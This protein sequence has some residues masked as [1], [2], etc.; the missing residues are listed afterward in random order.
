[1]LLTGF[2]KLDAGY[3]DN[4][5]GVNGEVFYV[6]SAGGIVPRPRTALIPL[7]T[8]SQS[9]NVSG[10]AAA[11]LVAS[12]APS[13]WTWP[14]TSGELTFPLH[15]PRGAVVT[16]VRVGTSNQSGGTAAITC[17]LWGKA[18][19]KTT[20]SLSTAAAVDTDTQNLPTLTDLVFTLTPSVTLTIDNSVAE[21]YVTVSAQEDCRLHWLDVTYSD[22]GP[23]NG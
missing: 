16:N 22:P 9:A 21:Y 11:V 13:Y 3:V 6:D 7:P 2:V 5:W 12:S 19:N 23:R 4:D 14:T 15:L 17:S 8:A 1:L 18:A 10:V 20:P